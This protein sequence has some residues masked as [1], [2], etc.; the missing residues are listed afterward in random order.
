M[1]TYLVIDDEALI[2][3]GIP[4]LID[5][6]G[7]GYR[8]LGTGEDGKEGLRLILALQPDLV[9][10]DIKMPGMTGLAMIAEARKAGFQGE[11]VILTAHSQFDYAKTAI[12]VGVE[13]Y[14]LKPIDEDELLRVIRT[15]RAK[16]AASKQQHTVR[17][18]YEQLRFHASLRS[19]LLKNRIDDPVVREM[20]ADY[21]QDQGDCACV[22]LVLDTETGPG[23]AH[24]A[25]EMQMDAR[26][27]LRG[28]EYP[29]FMLEGSFV[30]VAFG[31]SYPE[32]AARIRES[33]LSGTYPLAIGH[34]VFYW[35]DLSYSYEIAKLLLSRYFLFDDGVILDY[36]RI[37]AASHV[38]LAPDPRQLVDALSFGDEE[39]I[40]SFLQRLKLTFQRELLTEEATKH[41]LLL[42]LRQVAESLPEPIE[43]ERE[44]VEA[45]LRGANRLEAALQ[46]LEAVL[47]RWSDK[48]QQQ[49]AEEAGSVS[50]VEQLRYY[51][52]QYYAE[53]LSLDAMA[54]KLHYNSNYLGRIFR[55]E[56]GHSFA[57]ELEIVRLE[58]AAEVL[59]QTELPVYQIAQSVGF[60]HADSFYQK[61]RQQYGMTPSQYRQMYGIQG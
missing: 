29:G 6:E 60:G 9:L 45:C 56:R 15:L 40:K 21:F 24:T 41:R 27:P 44:A 16:I 46:K 57:R 31:L 30:Q 12:S 2:R 34:D 8:L 10:V 4:L 7:E 54:E 19:V 22:L 1:I 47:L 14:L 18:E 50:P 35:E 38:S 49:I 20:L 5:W 36:D 28:A 25:F 55:Q 51:I 52:R 3:E 13:E 53:A 17:E 43:G 37:L 26:P 32:A 58:R 11:F 48:L 42:L 39:G 23:D 61:F 33:G 59:T